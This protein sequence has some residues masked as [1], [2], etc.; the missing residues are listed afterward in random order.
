MSAKLWVPGVSVSHPSASLNRHGGFAVVTLDDAG[1][2]LTVDTPAEA[3]EV[4]AAFT[5]AAVLLEQAQGR[6]APVTRDEHLAWCKER[7][8]EYAD[9]GETGNAI[10]SL[11][12]DLRKHPETADSVSIVADLMMP[13]AMIGDF[14]RPGELRKFIEGFS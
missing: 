1:T 14:E 6:R 3:R 5:E 2:Y 11:A 7:A 9:Q 8:L 10:A 12:S 4:G 13:L